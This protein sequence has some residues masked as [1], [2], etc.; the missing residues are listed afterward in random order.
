MYASREGIVTPL[1]PQVSFNPSANR[2]LSLS[3]DGT[4]IALDLV[5]A[6][7]PD[8]WIKQLP[9]G[10]LSRLTF[11]GLGSIRPRW[12]PDG[13]SVLYIMTPDSGLPSVWKKRAD[14]ST[15]AELVWRD[16]A[17][18]IA[19]ASFSNDGQWLIYRINQPDG[20]RDI[21]AVRPGRDTV[22]TP[23]LTG[24][25][26]EQGAA[27]SPDGKW[28]AYTSNESGTNEIFVRPFPS[29]NAGRWQISTSGGFAARWA[30]SGR[31]LFYQSAG[32]D[33]MVVPVMPGTTFAPGEA[34]RLFPLGRWNPGVRHRPLLRSHAR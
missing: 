1:N 17:R 11:D 26:I 5:G 8:I 34:R 6:A 25:F 10:P 33:L 3:P 2:S 23:L 15:A 24:P 4:R 9:A 12:T 27:L 21:Y 28:L 18:A 14:G 20:N 16:P 19:E 32:G 13:R 7:S 29:T 22:P 31:E 30:H